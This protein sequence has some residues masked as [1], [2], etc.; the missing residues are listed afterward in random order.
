LEVY[1]RARS[2]EPSRDSQ[3]CRRETESIG[4]WSSSRSSTKKVKTAEKL[5]LD[6]IAIDPKEVIDALKM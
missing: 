2:F 4:E 3:F 6:T 5:K 1:D